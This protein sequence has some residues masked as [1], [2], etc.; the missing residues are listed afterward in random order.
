MRLYYLATH[1]GSV[2][3]TDRLMPKAYAQDR[4]WVCTQK[5]EPKTNVLL[6][7]HRAAVRQQGILLG[8]CAAS[9][10]RATESHNLHWAVH[11]VGIRP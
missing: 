7:Q 5:I 2:G 8:A 9:Q 3:D 11:R 6:Y 10:D 4:H 1:L